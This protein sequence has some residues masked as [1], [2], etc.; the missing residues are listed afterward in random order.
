M[1][2]VQ[3]AARVAKTKV[4]RE[5]KKEDHEDEGRRRRRKRGGK[6][7]KSQM[8]SFHGFGATRLTFDG[9]LVE[10]VLVEGG[11]SQKVGGDVWDRRDVV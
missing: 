5:E 7:R 9:K 4:E 11:K 2:C 6:R 1:F 8:G 3:E 10:C